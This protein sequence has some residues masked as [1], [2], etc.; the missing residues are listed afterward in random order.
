MCQLILTNLN[1]P[2]LNKIFMSLLIQIDSMGNQDGTGVLVVNKDSVSVWKTAI[3]GDEISN[4]GIILRENI[5]SKSPVLGHV[6]SA[7]K[8]IKVD[9]SNAHP[10][11]GKRFV[12][13]HNGRLYGKDEV[14][15][16][17]YA[18][19]DT[20]MTSDSLLFLERIEREASKNKEMSVKDIINN[21][22]KDFKG[23]FAFML[24]DKSTGKHYVI[25]GSTA[26]LHMSILVETTYDKIEKKDVRS[27][28]G[29]IVNTKK[30][31]LN[32]AL[33][34]GIPIAQMISGKL[35]DN[36]PIFELDKESI[37]EVGKTGL[38]KLGEIKEN[39]VYSPTTSYIN[40][41][42][43]NSRYYGVIDNTPI[44]PILTLC[45]SVAKYAENHFLTVADID[46]IFLL[47][48]GSPMATCSKEQLK[49]FVD[50]VITRV[51]ATK[52]IR[53]RMK[54]DF[55]DGCKI[56][57]TAYSSVEGLEYPWM[58]ND[59]ETI[60]RLIKWVVKSYAS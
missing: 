60:N 14:V 46:A 51:N 25:R 16:N 50:E 42:S 11:S 43:N 41:H 39:P 53:K 36:D 32:D 52:V 21:S 26:D 4:L 24:Y 55:P 27:P 58:I 2:E 34:I 1:K 6:R 59:A 44:G 28:I 45:N 31:S 13:A 17:Y 18:N 29:Y 35:I 37:Y 12:I 23:K 8:G 20:S 9:D 15:S 19:D 56:W 38:I 49:F 47:Y 30:S 10:F 54:R 40:G 48:V 3:A 22:M 5:L 57:P 7:S 33:K